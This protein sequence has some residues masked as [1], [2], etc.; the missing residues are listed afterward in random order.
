MR[1]SIRIRSGNVFLRG[2]HF[3]NQCQVTALRMAIEPVREISRAIARL[4]HDFHNQFASRAAQYPSRNPKYPDTHRSIA[5]ESTTIKPRMDATSPTA[6]IEARRSGWLSKTDPRSSCV[7]GL[8]DIDSAFAASMAAV[9]G[10]IGVDQSPSA[11]IKLPSPAGRPVQGI[12]RSST[13]A[14][15]LVRNRR[16]ILSTIHENA[17]AVTRPIPSDQYRRTGNQRGN[18]R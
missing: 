12:A 16:N 13:N 14:S 11:A 8:G 17:P 5:A 10:R 6:T 1:L 4:D 18:S 2:G 3:N 15:D 9:T 7:A